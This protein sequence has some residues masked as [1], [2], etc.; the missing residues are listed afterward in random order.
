MFGKPV[1]DF[2]PYETALQVTDD[3]EI[4]AIVRAFVH[5]PGLHHLCVVNGAGR[6][7]GLINRKRLFKSIFSHHLDVD[8]RVSK[9]LLLHTAETSGDIMITDVVTTREDEEIDAVISRMIAKNIRELPVVDEDGR[10]I[11][12][13]TLQMLMQKWLAGQDGAGGS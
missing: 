8:S 6:L 11:G 3:A 1:R 7:L 9:L 12:F 13:L 4:V 10:V 2:R 5:A